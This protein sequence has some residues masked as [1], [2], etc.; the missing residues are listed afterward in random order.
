MRRFFV[1]FFCCLFLVFGSGCRTPQSVKNVWKETKYY[2][3]TYL[4]TPVTLNFEDQGDSE[5]Y[6]QTLASAV[7]EFDMRIGDLERVLQNSDKN[8]DAAWLARMTERFPWLSGLALTDA[9]GNAGAKLPMDYPKPFDVLPLLEEDPKQQIKDLRAFVQQTPQ[10]P[11]IYLDNPVY[12]GGDFRGLV[13]VHFDPRVLI[14]QVTNPGVFMLAGPDGIIWPGMFDAEATPVAAINWGEVVKDQSY[15]T[16][17]NEQGTF[18][19]VARYLGN[20]PLVYAVKVS[21]EFPERLEN[22]AGLTEALPFALGKLDLRDIQLDSGETGEDLSPGEVGNIGSP[23]V[24]PESPLRGE[25]RDRTRE[26]SA[27]DLAV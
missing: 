14:G 9:S 27:E 16:V 12:L 2:Y 3:Y 25:P 5:E 17:S 1:C 23:D 18:Y 8:P 19:W 4:N 21:G 6:Q 11:E 26:P 24:S 13:V 7:S 10:G 22:M 20:L 15:G